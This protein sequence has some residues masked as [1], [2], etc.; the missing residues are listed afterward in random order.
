MNAKNINNSTGTRI[1]NS[2]DNQRQTVNF[3]A[4]SFGDDLNSLNSEDEVV[5]I[6]KGKEV[7]PIQRG[8]SFRNND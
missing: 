6:N 8:I 7:M 4:N 5:A 3:L 1:E 2:L